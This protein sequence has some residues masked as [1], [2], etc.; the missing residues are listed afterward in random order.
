MAR[1]WDAPLD[2]WVVT[3]DELRDIDAA[4]RSHRIEPL[5]IVGSLGVFNLVLLCRAENNRVVADF[6]NGLSGW[7]TEA[8]LAT[9]HSRW[10]FLGV[11]R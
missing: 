3:P 5:D 11:G 1:A 4:V 9:S 10:E 2:K 8:L 7:Q 6:L